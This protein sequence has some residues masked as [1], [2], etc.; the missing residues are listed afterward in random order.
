MMFTSLDTFS[1]SSS[2]TSAAASTRT[3][4][5]SIL[6]AP[7]CSRLLPCTLTITWFGQAVDFFPPVRVRG[8]DRQVRSSQVFVR[9]QPHHVR[10]PH[11]R[12]K[13]VRKGQGR[14]LG[15]VNQFI[16]DAHATPRKRK[17][18]MPDGKCLDGEQLS[19]CKQALPPSLATP[20]WHAAKTLLCA[21]PGRTEGL[22]HGL[23]TDKVQLED[24]INKLVV[25][26]LPP[27]ATQSCERDGGLHV[28]VTTTPLLTG[29][30][31]GH[32]PR[33]VHSTSGSAAST[34]S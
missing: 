26:A 17:A 20:A 4:Q 27:A 14:C 18:R 16:G 3:T 33:Q 30:R 5:F 7:P 15:L 31:Y 21:R 12:L 2:V 8:S 9:R 32:E 22:E 6:T 1:C 25:Q 11:D 13:E 19:L 24:A 10:D 34:T 28:I 23:Q 29:K